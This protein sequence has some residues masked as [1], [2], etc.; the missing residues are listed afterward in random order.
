MAST[1]DKKCR[2]LV[3]LMLTRYDGDWESSFPSDMGIPYD[4]CRAMFDKYAEDVRKE[5]EGDVKVHV[6]EPTAEE[7]MRKGMLRLNL[8]IQKETDP[9]KIARALQILNELKDTGAVRKEDK[10]SIF[11]KLNQDRK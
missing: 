11:D 5:I 7:T 10:T 2:N 3:Y 4:T 9:S 6:K 1:S 8:Q